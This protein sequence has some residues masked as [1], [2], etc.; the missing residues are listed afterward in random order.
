MVFEL[1]LGFVMAALFILAYLALSRLWQDNEKA[2]TGDRP[3][4]T[5]SPADSTRA[6]GPGSSSSQNRRETTNEHHPRRS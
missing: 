4:V 2:L 3:Y 6:I 1:T 5:L